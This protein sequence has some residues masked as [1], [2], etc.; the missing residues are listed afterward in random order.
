MFDAGF[1]IWKA[2][3]D[4]YQVHGI[5]PLTCRNYAPFK[6]EDQARNLSF[7]LNFPLTPVL[8]RR[9]VSQKERRRG[10]LRYA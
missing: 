2:L 10:R 6:G 1:L 5:S 7:R 4:G 9:G 8:S 3:E